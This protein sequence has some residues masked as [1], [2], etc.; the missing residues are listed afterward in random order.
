MKKIIALLCCVLL[1]LSQAACG[2]VIPLLMDGGSADPNNPDAGTP[3]PSPTPLEVSAENL[4]NAYDDNAYAA[5]EQYK[6]KRLAVAGEV[7]VVDKDS[8]GDPYVVLSG[9]NDFEVTQVRCYFDAD[10]DQAAKIKGLKTGDKATIVG[11]CTGKGI[12]DVEL[13]DCTIK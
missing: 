1:V 11:E 4:I 8:S 6:D 5:D 13:M 3:T 9:G 2:A 10:D 12:F 7:Y